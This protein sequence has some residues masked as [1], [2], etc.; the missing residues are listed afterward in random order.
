[1]LIGN[2]TTESA[3]V[4][5]WGN[6]VI[7]KGGPIV[8]PIIETGK[9]IGGSLTPEV[10][11]VVPVQVTYMKLLHMR[12]KHIVSHFGEVETSQSGVEL[13]WM[14][15]MDGHPPLPACSAKKLVKIPKRNL[16]IWKIRVIHFGFPFFVFSSLKYQ[17]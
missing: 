1:M 13:G 11:N 5:L 16:P 4:I 17:A 2:V 3:R 6:I 15:V 10:G 14:C 9:T 12:A 7:S 8:H